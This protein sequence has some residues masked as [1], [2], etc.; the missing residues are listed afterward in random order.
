M[1]SMHDE[2]LVDLIYAKVEAVEAEAILG[3]PETTAWAIAEAEAWAAA[4]T[5]ACAGSQELGAALALSAGITKRAADVLWVR[6][7]I[8][9]CDRYVL[10]SLD[11]LQAAA[12]NAAANEA[13]AQAHN[14]GGNFAESVLDPFAEVAWRTLPTRR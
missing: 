13:F 2:E 3:E 8:D 9:W 6:Y 10:P 1:A 11:E 4:S 5:M 7:L 12:Y 14:D